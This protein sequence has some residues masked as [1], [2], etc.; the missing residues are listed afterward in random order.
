MQRDDN[1]E[2][3]GDL[4]TVVA[5]QPSAGAVDLAGVELGDQLD[6]PLRQHPAEMLGS[7]GLRE[8]TVERRRVG[9]VDLI[10]DAALGEVPVGQ[11]AELERCDGA[12]D[13]H[14]DH[15]HH[16]TAPVE[17]LQRGAER[18]SAF[19]CVEGEH[20]VHPPWPGEALG[21]V[22]HQ[23]CPGCDDQHVVA[24]AS[25][26]VEMDFLGDDVDPVDG[27]L[28]EGDARAQLP[29]AGADDVLAVGQ[30]EGN[31]QQS[32]LIDVAVILVDDGDLG[33][34]DA[35]QASQPVCR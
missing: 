18:G 15:V 23:P 32:R 28:D 29:F 13:R 10:A 5:D 3:E 34:I 24:E 31:E 19:G 1:G 21:L 6:S 8:R 30:S 12:L 9:D 35:V 14:V 25:A 16:Q 2:V 17:G 11:E 4:A 7:D 33:L 27:G 20:V 22:R 26:V